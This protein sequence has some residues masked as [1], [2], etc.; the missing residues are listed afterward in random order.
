M[1]R[2][3][4]YGIEVNP[5][6]Q[7]IRRTVANPLGSFIGF[8]SAILFTLQETF[9]ENRLIDTTK[10]NKT[11]L[12]TKLGSKALCQASR[13]PLFASDAPPRPP[14]ASSAHQLIR[15]EDGERTRHVETVSAFFLAKTERSSTE[16]LLR[17][18]C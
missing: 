9:N 10:Q 7:R 18:A 11:I 17:R 8:G 15:L 5:G 2:N 16:P 14:N 4:D 1:I 6:Q 3:K 12:T 13:F